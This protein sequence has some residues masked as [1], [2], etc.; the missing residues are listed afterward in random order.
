MSDFVFDASD[1]PPHLREE[2]AHHLEQTYHMRYGG[3]EL[4]ESLIFRLPRD[5]PDVI[6]TEPAAVF[7]RELAAAVRSGAVRMKVPAMTQQERYQVS[8]LLL[9]SA[10]RPARESRGPWDHPVTSALAAM[11]RTWDATAK[12]EGTPDQREA[13]LAGYKG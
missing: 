3:L 10:E 7:L 6:R 11:C 1:L 13:R 4:T 12:V 5:S 8:A 9:R 2:V